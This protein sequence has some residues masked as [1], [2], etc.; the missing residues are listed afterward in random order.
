MTKTVKNELQN[1]M[2]IIEKMNCVEWVS[3]V[4]LSEYDIQWLIN[5]DYEGGNKKVVRVEYAWHCYANPK[6]IFIEDFLNK[7]EKELK[8]MIEI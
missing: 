4:D 1:K 5:L 2:E 8:E 6:Y 3:L 7:S